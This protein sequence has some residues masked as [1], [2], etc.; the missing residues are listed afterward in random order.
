MDPIKYA[1]FD[2][3][4]ES[5]CRAVRESRILSRTLGRDGIAQYGGLLPVEMRMLSRTIA[6]SK[7]TVGRLLST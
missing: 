1:P 6:E 4:L 3:R 5:G 7:T 2:P